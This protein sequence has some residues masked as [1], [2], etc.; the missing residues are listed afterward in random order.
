MSRRA[1]RLEI[2]QHAKSVVEPK[3]FDSLRSLRTR[4]SRSD[5]RENISHLNY[6]LYESLV[7][8]KS[9]SLFYRMIIFPDSDAI[10]FVS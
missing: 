5:V 9:V 1:I 2:C 4:T 6:N 3:P 7:I 10:I 8:Y